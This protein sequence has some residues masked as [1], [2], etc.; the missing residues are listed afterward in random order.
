MVYSM[1]S[2]SMCLWHVTSMFQVYVSKKCSTFMSISHKQPK[3]YRFF[4]SVSHTRETS[5]H[6]TGSMPWIFYIKLGKWMK[7]NGYQA[8]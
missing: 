1:F 6:P 7:S 8:I 2:T 3:Q 5:S 4:H